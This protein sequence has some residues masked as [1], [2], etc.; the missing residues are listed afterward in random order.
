MEHEKLILKYRF[1]NKILILTIFLLGLSI[2][3][4]LA[5]TKFETEL[6][7]LIKNDPV[8]KGAVTGV[9]I[10]SGQSG[11]ILYQHQGDIRLRPASNLKLFTAAAALSVLGEN[12]T[13]KTELLTDGPFVG[14]MI[15]GNLYLKGKGDPTLLKEDF[16]EFADQLIEKGINVI[17]GHLVGDDSWFDDIRYPIDLPWSDEQAYYG[18][19]IS[20]LTA[21]P[22]KDYDSGTV[23]VS[24]EPAER[25]GQPAKITVLPQTTYVEIINKVKTVDSK[26]KKD[27]KMNRGHGTNII[28]ITG[29]IPVNS[30]PF[31]EWVAVW[32]PTGYALDLLKLSLSEKGIILNGVIKE[33][34][35]PKS[36]T[37]VASHS[38]MSLTDILVPFMKLSNNIHAET[39]IKEMGKVKKGEGSWEKGL[40][41]LETE[42]LGFGVDTNS[43]VLRDGS[44]VSHINLVPSNEISKLLFH[45]QEEKWFPV[46]LQALPVSGVREKMLGG[47]LRNRLYD[48]KGK[49]KAKTGTLSTVSSLSGY[50]KTNSGETLIFSIILN[51][52]LD[53][54]KGKEVEDKI[55]TILAN[56]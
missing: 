26:G 2:H 27:I 1:L 19:Q 39:L 31:L 16:D 54:E 23:V 20:A 49:I 15:M 6:S 33:G 55:V 48:V 29:N 8:L 22:D 50:V 38:S 47:S 51:N 25:I 45:V 40:E 17:Q 3:Q 35:T 44:G 10:R 4:T 46:F 32:N 9:S 42:L 30:K 36:A 21:S 11:E 12:Y 37:L 43:L 14:N 52:L 28:E 53:E 56:S 24:V 34:I 7:N 41:V 5:V 13:F 18:A